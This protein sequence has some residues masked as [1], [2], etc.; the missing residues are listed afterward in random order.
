MTDAAGYLRTL[1][2]AKAQTDSGRWVEAAALWEQ[3]V[4]ANL[5]NGN[6][7]DQLAQARFESRDY[8]GALAAYEKVRDL[9]VWD[10][11]ETVFPSEVWYGIACCHARRG[12]AD[13]ALRA[14]GRAVE[15]GLRDLERASR[16]EHPASLHA[17][18]RLRDLLGLSDVD[19]LGRDE[20]WRADLRFFAREVGRRA[21]RPAE[22]RR[23]PVAS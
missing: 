16:D 14:L 10:Q 18:E 7:W 12:D 1:A 2:R 3:V 20:G 19:G 21:Y 23:E 22:S 5:I 15:L 17:D 4:A 13:E 11:R 6:H 9:G 8:A